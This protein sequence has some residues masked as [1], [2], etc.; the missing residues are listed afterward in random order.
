MPAARDRGGTITNVDG[1]RRY[2][3]DKYD[4]CTSNT[5]DIPED[6]SDKVSLTVAIGSSV[7]VVEKTMEIWND[8]GD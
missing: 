5:R 4:R 1:K 6:D 8:D 3:V 2:A 7:P